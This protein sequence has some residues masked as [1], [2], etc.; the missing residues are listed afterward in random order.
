MERLSSLCQVVFM[1][2]IA[3]Y[4]SHVMEYGWNMLPMTS[5]THMTRT[6]ELVQVSGNG[7]S[8]DI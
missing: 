3:T 5:W 8:K 4:L 7:A 2:S 1:S 6:S